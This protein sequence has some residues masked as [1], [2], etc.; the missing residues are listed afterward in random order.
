MLNLNNPVSFTADEQNHIS[1][2]L[3]PLGKEGWNKNDHKTKAIKHKISAYT[4][5]NQQCRCA[6]CERLLERGG[7]QIEHI[8]P[9]DSNGNFCYE[10]YNLVS[11]CG[12]CNSIT[13]KG[14]NDT[15]LPPKSNN[16]IS[17]EFKIVHPYIDDPDEHIKYKDPGRTVFDKA[18][19]SQKGLDTID[20]FNWDTLNAYIARTTIASSRSIPVPIAQLI[21]EISLYK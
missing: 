17:N 4:L 16:Y 7:V 12:I 1:N 3:K 21:L 9:K 6:Y 11:A 18:T 8:A 14:A 20:L 2:I 5:Q 19:C 15:I 13:N 10:P